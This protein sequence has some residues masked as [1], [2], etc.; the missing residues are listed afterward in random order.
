MSEI[1]KDLNKEIERKISRFKKKISFDSLEDSEKETA[2]ALFDLFYNALLQEKKNRTIQS[3]HVSA[4][5]KELEEY[6]QKLKD[7]NLKMS[8]QSRLAGIGEMAANLSHEINNP[9]MGINLNVEKVKILNSRDL[10]P[11]KKKEQINESCSKIQGVVKKISNII[12]GLS[13][14]SNQSE[15]G[16]KSKHSFRK[17]YLE[18]EAFSLESFK[19]N[20]IKYTCQEIDSDLMIN[21]QEVQF[22]QVILNLLTNALHAVRNLET[23]DRWI[24]MSYKKNNKELEITFKNGG[25]QIPKEYQE[26]IFEPFF[27][28]KQVGEGTGLGLQLCK[29]ILESCDASIKLNEKSPNP[30]FTIKI[31]L[32]Y[33]IEI[34]ILQV[35]TN[36]RYPNRVV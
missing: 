20:R 34:L 21:V 6:I 4:M 24:D 12:R 26:R 8:H 1:K 33:K 17:L 27:T 30:S 13:R 35:R 36:K 19:N 16:V 15:D 14:I 9:L 28:T 18:T 3:M 7:N 11:E 29:K 32:V 2:K 23:E 10:D 22:S 31:P 25:P 5:N